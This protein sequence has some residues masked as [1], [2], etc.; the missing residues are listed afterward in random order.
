MRLEVGV[1]ADPKL[2]YPEKP[3][4]SHLELAGNARL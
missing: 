1:V 4:K 3:L 2:G